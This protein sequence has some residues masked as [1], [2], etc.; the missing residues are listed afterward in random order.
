MLSD[1]IAGSSAPLSLWGSPVRMDA[2]S[3]AKSKAKGAPPRPR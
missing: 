3:D 1:H 2:L